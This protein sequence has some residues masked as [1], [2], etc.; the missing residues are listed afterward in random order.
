MTKHQKE[1]LEKCK[2]PAFYEDLSLFDDIYILPTNQRHDSGFKIMLIVGEV[3][4]T[5]EYYLIDACCDVVNLG[6]LT[7][8]IK[9]VNIDIEHSKIIHLW[10]NYQLFKCGYRLSS[11]TFE[12]VD[13][14]Q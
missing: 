1:L 5:E 8:Q 2:R 4:E 13:R 9:E 6:F 3:R 10:S 14:R 12:F 11:C 7:K